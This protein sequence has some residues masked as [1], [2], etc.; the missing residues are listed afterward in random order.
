MCV[1]VCCVLFVMLCFRNL[2]MS[3]SCFNFFIFFIIFFF[4]LVFNVLFAVFL[5]FVPVEVL[6][7]QFDSFFYCF[8]CIVFIFMPYTSGSLF[9]YFFFCLF[10]SY[11]S[12]FVMFYTQSPPFPN[13]FLCLSPIGLV[14]SVVFLVI[15][16]TPAHTF[17]FSIATRI[18]ALRR[19]GTQSTALAKAG[20]RR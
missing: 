4:N 12:I 18:L 20:R 14:P 16:S 2:L 9:P 5:F 6:F 17:F 11:S 10:V 3:L 15:F 7:V 8:S 1:F 19:L 13:F